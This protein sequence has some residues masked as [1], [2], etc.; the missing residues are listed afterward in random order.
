VGE[1]ERRTDLVKHG[2]GSDT[3][4]DTGNDWKGQALITFSPGPNT[5]TTLPKF[6]NDA[7]ASE[8]VLAPTVI[9]AGTPA[10][11]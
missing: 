3:G 11:E 7:L 1:I 8:M 6:E 10:G 9:A 2:S 5:S 4:N